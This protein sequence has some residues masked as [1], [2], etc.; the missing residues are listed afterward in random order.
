MGQLGAAREHALEAH[1]SGPITVQ[2]GAE[3][4]LGV[5]CTLGG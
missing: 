2:Q 4:K 3:G 1:I 5:F